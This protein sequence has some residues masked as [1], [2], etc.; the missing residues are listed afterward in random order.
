MP[1]TQLRMV[2]YKQDE[3]TLVATNQPAPKSNR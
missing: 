3:T 2:Q 1:I